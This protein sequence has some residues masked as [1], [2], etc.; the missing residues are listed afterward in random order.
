MKDGE[1]VRNTSATGGEK[2]RKLAQ[3]GAIDPLALL[4]LA[5][6]AGHGS[7]KYDRYNY[8]RGYDW[9]DSFDAAQ[10]HLLAYWSGEDRDPESGQL[11][12]AHAA[13][14]CL[15]QVSFI[16]REIG[17]DN[18][19]EAPGQAWIPFTVEQGDDLEALALSDR[20]VEVLGPWY[21]VEEHVL[22]AEID[23]V[24]L[25]DNDWRQLRAVEVASGWYEVTNASE[26]GEFRG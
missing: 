7:E 3:L 6:V 23:M 22:I 1:E 12:A 21:P 2:G 24:N 14:H 8:L 13:W 17:T 19:P 15:A 9:A 25:S 10:R 18:R 11:H 16:L 4:E 20:D 5:K 26:F